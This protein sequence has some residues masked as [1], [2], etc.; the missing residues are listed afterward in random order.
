MAME[1]YITVGVAGHVDHGK[2]SLVRCLT[3]I[4]T[5][6]LKEEKRRGLTIEP[7]IA[8]LTLPSG[9]TLALVDVP[10]HSDYLKNTIRGL[11][12]VDMAILVVAADDGV[13]P[14]TLDHLE[15]LNFM[16]ARSGI[17][18]LSKVDLVDEETPELAELEIREIL[19]GTFLDGKP[20]IPF[21]A[22][23]RRGANEILAAIEA[24]AGEISGK[25][26]DLPFR[27]WIDQVRSFPGFGTVASG[28][29][30]TGSL[31]R[32]D[33]V[34]ILPSGQETKA[35]FLEVHH[36]RVD[37]AVT[38]Q[39]VGINLHKIPMDDVSA[40]MTLAAPGALHS[41][42]ILNAELSVLP[43]ARKPISDRQRVKLYAGTGATNGLVVLMERERL[44]PGETG[45]VQIRLLEPMALLPK[46]PYVI[47]PLNFHSVVGGGVILEAAREKYRAVKTRQVVSYL[48]PLQKGDVRGSVEHYFLR[49][50]LEPA[51]SRDV[52]R[53]TGFDTEQVHE[54]ILSGVARGEI[55]EIEGKGFFGKAR[56]NALKA[57]IPE[58]L[59]EF[60]TQNPLTTAIKPAQIK[61][62][63]A[64]LLDDA[65]LKKML[66]DL[67]EEGSIERLGSGYHLPDFKAKLLPEQE[68]LA[69]LLLRYARSS[70]LVPFGAG[71]FCKFNTR[72]GTF[73]V[74]EIQK[75]LDH[76]H[77]RGKLIRL[78][79]KRYLTPSAFEEI[80]KRV[81][82]KIL[83]AG[84]LIL[85]DLKDLIGYGRTR[86]IPVL[87][88]LDDIGFTVRRGDGRVLKIR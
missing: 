20:L 88:Y 29:I 76:L 12:S 32:D 68:K 77:V 43:K 7:G 31:F 11:S 27:L 54:A 15:V 45:L 84:S 10:G 59:N 64:L 74:A 72:L 36:Q 13:M 28:T 6:R 37:Q 33:P 79:D 24:T 65:L 85:D 44:N 69:A 66:A 81:G 2:T 80:K 60:F 22:T 41:G 56:F 71:K 21:S 9:R 1:E 8:P 34:Q 48:K 57:R 52:A 38:G 83:E 75:I 47:S 61:I 62:R 25:N 35:R 58:V 82:E 17:V 46:D 63:L 26:K 23:D 42:Y 55:I 16:K 39:R 3:G 70:D 4:D 67:S 5:D 53:E 40:G 30:L 87:E 78:N 14:Q 18:V 49:G 73:S 50:L 19:R 51:T 86:A